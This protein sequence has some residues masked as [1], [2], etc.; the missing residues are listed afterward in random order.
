[1]YV[2]RKKMSNSKLF[3]PL[4]LTIKGDANYPT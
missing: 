2:I 4:E 1:M 3:F